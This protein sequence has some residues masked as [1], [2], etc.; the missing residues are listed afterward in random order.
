MSG[1]AFD[2]H[3]AATRFS[4]AGFSDE[5]VEVLANLT[6]ETPAWPDTSTL[7]TKA[8]V[9]QLAVVDKAAN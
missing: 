4:Q 5:Q 8:D 6:P 7:A 1:I 2:T 9:A 3:S